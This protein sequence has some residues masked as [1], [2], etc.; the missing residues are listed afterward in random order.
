MAKYKEVRSTDARVIF[1]Y[2]FLSAGGNYSADF[3]HGLR[4]AGAGYNYLS[5]CTLPMERGNLLVFPHGE[6]QAKGQIKGFCVCLLK[7]DGLNE[8]G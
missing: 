2:D 8:L 5:C 1:D 7:N 4:M 3:S 6:E